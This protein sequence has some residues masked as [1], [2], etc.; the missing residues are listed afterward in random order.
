VRRFGLD[1]VCG[2]GHRQLL[3]REH[4]LM[5]MA[6]LVSGIATTWAP[7]HQLRISAELLGQ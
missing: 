5:T 4:I 3:L 7:P 2:P 1:G 6:Q